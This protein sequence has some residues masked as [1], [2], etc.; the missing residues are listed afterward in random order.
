VKGVIAGLVLLA[1]GILV[2]VVGNSSSA[3]FVVG[4]VLVGLGAIALA[5]TF[6]Y[7]VGRSEDRDR[8]RHPT[9]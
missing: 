5:S 8:E 2:S 3:W 1:V 4:L 6:F 7:A 9:G